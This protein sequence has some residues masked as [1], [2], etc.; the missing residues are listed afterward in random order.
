MI[1]GDDMEIF[2]YLND[3]IYL[4][5]LISIMIVSGIAKDNRL[6][7]G[8]YGFLKSKF[9][10]NR[11]VI[12]LLSFVSGI[13]PIEGRAT[14]S[15]GILDTA[16]STN[17]DTASRKK[18]GIID[19]LTTHHFYMWSPIEKPVLLPMAAFGLGYS[20]WLNLLWPLL[21]VSGLYIV[22]YCWLSVKENEVEIAEN[23]DNY[24]F[25]EFAKNTLPFPAAIVAYMILGGEG[26]EAVFPVFGALLAYYIVITRSFNLARLSSYVNWTT[27]A[28]VAVVF[29]SSG[30]MQEH[31]AWFEEVVKSIGLDMHT[32]KGVF[33]IS[34]L[35]FLASFSM[36]SDGKFAALT[37]L[38]A[39]AFGSE[40]L[41]WFF[42]LDYCGYL[43]TPMH[44]CVLI[45]KRYFGTSLTTYYTALL[46][47]AVLL[48]SVAGVF[49]FL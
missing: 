36:G 32:F 37:V 23:L 27:V 12:M 24:G 29:A 16:T 17:G 19:F 44:E 20:A 34:L 48:L 40:Y 28:I 33:Y 11:L 1:S 4:F 39:S 41:L 5:V 8:T 14:V 9:K 25:G 22:L 30:Y 13:L 47:W 26:P 31:R 6:F 21:V 42:A 38:M 46:T 43:L 2:N 15:A 10:S 45:G 49:T 7:A 18:L 3:E 35:T